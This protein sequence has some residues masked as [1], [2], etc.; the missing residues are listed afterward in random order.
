[1]SKVLTLMCICDTLKLKLQQRAFSKHNLLLFATVVMHLY[2]D[3]FVF[4][5]IMMDGC[6][7]TASGLHCWP[8]IN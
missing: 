5:Y 6:T 2:L 7:C 1:M 3:L 8:V 4:M